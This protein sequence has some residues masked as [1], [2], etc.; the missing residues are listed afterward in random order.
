MKNFFSI[1]GF[2][3]V[4]L[5]VVITI[6]GILATG[7]TTVYISAQQKARDSV[8]QTD[9]LSLKSAIEQAY[10]DIGAYPEAENIYGRLVDEEYL[11]NFPSDPKSGQ[12]DGFTLFVYRY[13]SAADEKNNVWGQEYELSANYENSGNANSKEGTDWDN[14]GEGDGGTINGNRDAGNDGIRWEI[15]VNMKNVNTEV[16]MSGIGG[17]TNDWDGDGFPDIKGNAI[18][19]DD[20]FDP[21][22][23][24]P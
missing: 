2:T 17:Q 4:E 18:T 14:S 21:N 13:G 22:Y 16:N 24:T 3:L 23:K 15:G 9:I 6:I 5:L 7:S 1:R 10:G 19:V 20:I 12:N 11:S 8:R